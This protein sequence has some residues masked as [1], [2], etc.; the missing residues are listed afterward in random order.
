MATLIMWFLGLRMGGKKMFLVHEV[1]NLEGD[2]MV[3]VSIGGMSNN[4]RLQNVLV[5]NYKDVL[6]KVSLRLFSSKS[7]EWWDPD[8]AS[9][10]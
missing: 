7:L 4:P 6:Q 8:K 3:G 2:A 5:P 1:A 10:Y 9:P